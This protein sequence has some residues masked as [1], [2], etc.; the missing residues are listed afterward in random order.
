MLG[1]REIFTAVGV[2]RRF[3]TVRLARGSP[4]HPLHGENFA[5]R[6]II[7]FLPTGE[8]VTAFRDES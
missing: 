1:E 8:N 7:E 2:S 6:I 4:R 3:A 5:V